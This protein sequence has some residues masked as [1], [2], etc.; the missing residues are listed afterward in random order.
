MESQNKHNEYKVPGFD[1]SVDSEQET[2]STF[3]KINLTVI[4]LLQLSLILFLFSL[5]FSVIG[6]MASKSDILL[7]HFRWQLKTHWLNILYSV[8]ALVIFVLSMQVEEQSA[9]W[10]IL[11]LLAALSAGYTPIII[12]HRALK[13][14]IFSLQNRPMPQPAKKT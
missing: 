14:L 7:S 11:I 6:V 1:P 3:Q 10:W 2:I 9:V 4:Y 12:I 13:G 5:I 8:L